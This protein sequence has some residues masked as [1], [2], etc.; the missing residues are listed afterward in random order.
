MLDGPSLL[1]RPWLVFRNGN[2]KSSTA[3]FGASIST[4]R[5]FLLRAAFAIAIEPVVPSLARGW[6]ENSRRAPAGVAELVDAPDL[7][8]GGENRGGSS[9]PPA[10]SPMAVLS[11]S[12]GAMVAT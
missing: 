3:V 10:P 8:S 5:S 1:S 4:L 11:G 6:G 9:P 2:H 12:A 7:G